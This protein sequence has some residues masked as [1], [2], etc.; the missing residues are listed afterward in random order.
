MQ[1][2]CIAMHSGGHLLVMAIPRFYWAKKMNGKK[3]RIYFL[4]QKMGGYAQECFEHSISPPVMLR[5]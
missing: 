5:C 4:D 2:G 3:G 1:R